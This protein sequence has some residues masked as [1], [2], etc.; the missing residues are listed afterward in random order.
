MKAVDIWMVID[1]NPSQVPHSF[2]DKA[3]T[4]WDYFSKF[5]NVQSDYK[6][7]A[8]KE[9]L[10]SVDK[11]LDLQEQGLVQWSADEWAFLQEVKVLLEEHDAFYFRILYAN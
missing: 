6:E 8:H 9:H 3:Y 1:L 2:F 7:W 5:P 10:Y 11:L 4:Y